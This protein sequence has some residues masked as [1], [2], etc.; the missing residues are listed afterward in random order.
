MVPSKESWHWGRARPDQASDGKGQDVGWAMLA[1]SEQPLAQARYMAWSRPGQGA[2]G[3]PWV[4]VPTGEH[5]SQNGDSDLD[6][7]WLHAPSA[8]I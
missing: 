3:M 7:T 2:K 5:K 8:W 6:Q 1:E 4:V